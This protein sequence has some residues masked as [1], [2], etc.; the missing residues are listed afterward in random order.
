MSIR[1]YGKGFLLQFLILMHSMVKS[2]M[3]GWWMP[4]HKA[5][6]FKT[7]VA[8]NLA[9]FNIRYGAVSSSTSL[10][11][12]SAHDIKAIDEDEDE[13]YAYTSLKIQM[14]VLRNMNQMV[15]LICR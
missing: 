5:W 14:N 1:K 4:K 6:F 3:G 10:G 11:S 2:M 13:D 12:N 7:E 9:N 15:S 8:Q